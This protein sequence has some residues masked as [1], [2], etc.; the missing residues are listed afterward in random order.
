MKKIYF[1]M[2]FLVACNLDEYNPSGATAGAVWT[3]PQGFITLVNAA[4]S[5]QRAWYGKEDGLFMGESGT[6]LWFN[7]NKDNYAV[8]TMRYENFTPS[9][10]NPNKAGWKLL[11][12]AINLCNAGIGR[13]GSA[14]FTDTVER[15]GREGELHFL[16]AFYYWHVVET[17]GGVML[18]TKETVGVTL[19]ATRSPVKDFYQLIT[20]DLE[21]AVK[22]LPVSRGTDYSRATRK[23]ALGL[24]ARVY[25][26]GAYYYSGAEAQSWF[27]KAQ[28]TANEVI[29]RKAEFGVDLWTNY[30]DLWKPQNN[31]QNKEA[32]Y[33]ISNSTNVALNYDGNA[34]RLHLW[35]LTTYSSKPGMQLSLEYGKDNNRRFMPT[36]ALLD[37]YDESKDA[38]YNSSFQEA[39]ICNK[40]YT[41]TAADVASYKKDPSLIGK[42]MIPGSDT[43]LYVTKKSIPDKALLPYIVIDRDSTY[44]ANG[45]IYGANDFVQLKKFMDPITRVNANSYPGYLDIFVIRLAEMYLIAAESAFQQGDNN[46]A[47]VNINVLR[48][49]AA[50]KAPVDHTADMQITAADINLDFILDERARELAGEHLRWFDLK[51]TGKLVD[52]IHQYNLDVTQIQ[53]FHMLRPVPQVELDALTNGQEF[54]QNEGYK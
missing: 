23:S 45:S 10:S 30:A 37:F 12:K 51:R 7:S 32:L 21:Y 16:R 47:A 19:T 31:K 41:W 35:F 26:S 11:Y 25:L 49:R 27:K 38:R 24:L 14:G 6:D 22:Y 17:Y 5:E 33:I 44:H 48:T 9:T 20:S 4:Y 43:M 8:E 2:I 42:K 39:W 52:R 34:N 18:L 53:S 40:A 13:I 15:N 46:A 3:T 1:I 50:I 29:N 54:G 28:E 36:R